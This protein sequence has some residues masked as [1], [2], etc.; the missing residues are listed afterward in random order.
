MVA[1]LQGEFEAGAELRIK[2][3]AEIAKLKWPALATRDASVREMRR[4]CHD[5]KGEAG[6]FGFPLLTDI[7]DLFGDYM[8]ETA[9]EVQRA[10][11]IKGYIDAFLVVW[12]QRI[13]GEGGEL[14]KQLIA[15]LSKL[16]ER[17]QARV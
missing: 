7:A 2:K 1:A 8:R 12:G 11:A 13:K 3:I 14:G 10:E 15:S 16:N 4:L 9:I 6:T 5:L 17:S